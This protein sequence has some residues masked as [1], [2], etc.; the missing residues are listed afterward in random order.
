M[1]AVA[2]VTY[3]VAS[4]AMCNMPRSNSLTYIYSGISSLLCRYYSVPVL[5]KAMADWQSR[6]DMHDADLIEDVTDGHAWGSIIDSDPRFAAETRHVGL[7]I[8]FDP[9][10]VR[11]VADVYIRNGNLRFTVYHPVVPLL[12]RL[13]PANPISPY[14]SSRT[15]SGFPCTRSLHR[16]STYPHTSVRAWARAP[17]CAWRRAST[18]RANPLMWTASWTSSLTS[19]FFLM[20]SESECMIHSGMSILSAT[21]GWSFTCQTIADSRSLQSCQA[22]QRPNPVHVAGCP[23][24]STL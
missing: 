9:F 2:A 12:T 22:H 3:T 15:T 13:N 7:S 24:S 6:R 16:C 20:R 18:K 8:F 5:A 19:W 1:C 14:S 21:R 23:G 11:K 10:Q 4:T 17:C